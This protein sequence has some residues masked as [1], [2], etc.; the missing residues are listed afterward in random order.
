[1]VPPCGVDLFQVL[2]G[3]CLVKVKGCPCVQ[4]GYAQVWVGG[5]TLGVIWYPF[6]SLILI[7]YHPT[8]YNK[9]S[10]TEELI[11]KGG[12]HLYI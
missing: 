2:E 4:I 5:I 6:H 9:F 10:S 3:R 7:P 11:K 12:F 1:M 8:L